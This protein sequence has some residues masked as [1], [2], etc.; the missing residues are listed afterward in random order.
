MLL[1]GLRMS[2]FVKKRFSLCILKNL[3]LE[4]LKQACF[5]HKFSLMAIFFKVEERLQEHQTVIKKT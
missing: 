3:L 1:V 4:L 5:L 2:F